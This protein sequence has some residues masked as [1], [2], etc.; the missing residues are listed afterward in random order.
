MDWI[1]EGYYQGNFVLT[2]FDGNTIKAGRYILLRI[3]A[4]KVNLRI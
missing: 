2:D 4:F 3:D 1:Q